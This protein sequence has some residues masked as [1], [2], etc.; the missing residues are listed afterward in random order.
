M[1]AARNRFGRLGWRIGCGLALR[2]T[3]SLRF[4]FGHALGHFQEMAKYFG[5]A[6]GLGEPFPHSL[7]LGDGFN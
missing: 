6:K 1:G 2:H 3:P 7:R 4:V 5:V